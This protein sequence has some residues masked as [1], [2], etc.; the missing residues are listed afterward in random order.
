MI[1]KL[2]DALLQTP[3]PLTG[4]GFDAAMKDAAIE[5]EMTVP[6]PQAIGSPEPR[7]DYT[8]YKTPE[9]KQPSPFA[10]P[11]V[12]VPASGIIGGEQAQAPVD[13]RALNAAQEAIAIVEQQV[14]RQ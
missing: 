4:E 12:T 10:A 2:T 14:P 7:H 1:E 13:Q 9:D 5:R 3:R 11:E 6:G 8:P